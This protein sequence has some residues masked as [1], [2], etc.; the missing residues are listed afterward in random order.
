LQTYLINA[1]FLAALLQVLEL[2]ANMNNKLDTDVFIPK[3]TLKY[4]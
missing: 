3:D 2:G 4:F 1:V